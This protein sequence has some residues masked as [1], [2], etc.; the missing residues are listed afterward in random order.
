MFQLE[1]L[2]GL[3]DLSPV[4]GSRVPQ[5][6]TASLA[7]NQLSLPDVGV[8]TSEFQPV[9]VPFGHMRV[10]AG[11]FILHCVSV[12]LGDDHESADALKRDIDEGN[13]TLNAVEAS[14]VGR[15]LVD[16]EVLDVGIPAFVCQLVPPR[17]P[18]DKGVVT[19]NQRF[20]F[21]DLTESLLDFR[22]GAQIPG[23]LGVAAAVRNKEADGAATG[24]VV[25]F[26]GGWIFPLDAAAQRLQP[27]P[28]QCS[29]VGHF[30]TSYYV[31]KHNE[32]LLSEGR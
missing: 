25:V 21:P 12:G 28:E 23:G 26:P 1:F 6:Q 13:H 10:P 5:N 7:L 3:A 27:L 15:V 14:L 29:R 24:P 22:M 16:V 4:D 19:A 2:A 20:S 18:T 32:T 31:P 17:S 11:E 9:A 30:F 8:F